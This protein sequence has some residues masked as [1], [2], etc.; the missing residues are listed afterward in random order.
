MLESDE[1]KMSMADTVADRIHLDIANSGL[2]AG[3][4]FMK[5]DQVAARYGISRTVAR[6]ALSR[7]HAIGVLESRQRV[8]LIVT[9]PDPVK[10]SERWVPMYCRAANRQDF[11]DL[12]QLRYALEMGSIDLAV[13]HADEEQTGRLSAL[14]QEFEAAAQ[15]TGHTPEADRLDLAF[16]TLILKMTRNPLIEGMHRVLSEYFSA[17][18]EMDPRGDAS[19]AIRD[20]HMIADAIRRRDVELTRSML[21]LHLGETLEPGDVDSR[22]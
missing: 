20:H 2:K 1:L 18:T 10:L 9:R 19:K 14:A 8:G 7:L 11:Q 4:L 17:S 12:A 3:E 16:H 6:E 13:A 5:G 15:D 22:G 21:R